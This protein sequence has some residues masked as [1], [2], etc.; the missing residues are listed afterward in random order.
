VLA[1]ALIAWATAFKVCELEPEYVHVNLGESVDFICTTDNW[2]ACSF[3]HADKCCK[4]IEWWT[5]LDGAGSSKTGLCDDYTKNR[6]VGLLPEG[7]NNLCGLRV[8]EARAEDSG[9]WEC[10]YELPEQYDKGG[11]WVAGDKATK[12][13][14]VVVVEGELE[15]QEVRVKLGCP[16]DFICTT[17]KTAAC[18]FKRYDKLCEKIEWEKTTDSEGTTTVG[19]CDHYGIDGNKW[20]ISGPLLRVGF[21]PKDGCRSCMDECGLRVTEARAEDEGEWECKYELPGQS[22]KEGDGDKATKIFQVVVEQPQNTTSEGELENY[23]GT[24]DAENNKSFRIA[25]SFLAVLMYM[26]L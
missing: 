24:N 21:K 19:Q 14:Q 12:K 26:C 16:V 20:A 13:F 7:D 10:E 6:R 18:T 9:E 1:F 17:D 23:C 25:A 5:S 4:E 22:D 8:S 3:K 2:K 15:K 11:R